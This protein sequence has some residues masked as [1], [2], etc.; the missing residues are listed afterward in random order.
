MS[1]KSLRPE[2]V[3]CD[4]AGC[5]P[6]FFCEL[7]VVARFALNHA[8]DAERQGEQTTSIELEMEKK[9]VLTVDNWGQRLAIS[10][11][12]TSFAGSRAARMRNLPRNAPKEANL[13]EF[14]LA[15]FTCVELQLL[16]SFFDHCGEARFPIAFMPQDQIYPARQVVRKLF[17]Y[18][19]WETFEGEIRQ[20]Q[21][22]NVRGVVWHADR[23]TRDGVRQLAADLAC[24]RAVRKL[25]DS[26]TLAAERDARDIA[27]ACASPTLT[28]VRRANSI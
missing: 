14:L 26:G 8:V 9:M 12:R 17:K 27:A 23:Q 1:H 3:A 4:P 15:N 16:N 20:I 7:S 21:E 24:W 5:T 25:L 11:W 28:N 6:A 19:L 22:Q 10:A 2:H 18:C 13:R